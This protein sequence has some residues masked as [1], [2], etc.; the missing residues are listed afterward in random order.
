MVARPE[1]SD[2]AWSQSRL[3]NQK[4]RCSTLLDGSHWWTWFLPFWAILKAL[5]H[6]MIIIGWF[7]CRR[8]VPT[9]HFQIYM[10][11]FLQVRLSSDRLAPRT[12]CVL[13]VVGT[14]GARLNEVQPRLVEV[15]ILLLSAYR[16][17]SISSLVLTISSFFPLLMPWPRPSN[18]Q[19]RLFWLKAKAPVRGGEVKWESWCDPGAGSLGETPFRSHQETW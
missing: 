1:L 17:A 19:K 10:N 12:C 9:L 4:L 2:S 5:V 13:P 3:Q 16:L 6:H 11:L 14:R 8:P 15:I 18:L 7:P